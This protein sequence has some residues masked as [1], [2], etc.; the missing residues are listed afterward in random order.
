MQVH[1][2]GTGVTV[3]EIPGMFPR[4]ACVRLD[5]VSARSRYLELRQVLLQASLPPIEAT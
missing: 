1:E 2:F 5:K 3:P 4:A